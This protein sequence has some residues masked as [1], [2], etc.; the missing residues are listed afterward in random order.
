M[1]ESTQRHT[2][3]M[4]LICMFLPRMVIHWSTLDF[5]IH[6]TVCKPRFCLV[7]SCAGLQI[8]SFMSQYVK[9]LDQI[10]QVFDTFGWIYLEI[11]QYRHNASLG[12]R[13]DSITFWEKTCWLTG[14]G[15]V[16]DPNTLWFLFY[17]GIWWSTQQNR[18]FDC[19]TSWTRWSS[20]GRRCSRAPYS[21]SRS[22]GLT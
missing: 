11:I 9:P 4:N 21:S 16:R 20:F 6:V 5:I 7:W 12:S 13:L 1:H 22:S 19:V 8:L 18:W 2:T 17:L 15:T 14:A 10:Y 3:C